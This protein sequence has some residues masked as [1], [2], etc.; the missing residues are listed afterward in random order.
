MKLTITHAVLLG[1]FIAAF[2]LLI[3]TRNTDGFKDLLA[4]PVEQTPVTDPPLTNPKRGKSD[5]PA[6]SD[7]SEIRDYI[8]NKPP[9]PGVD[10]TDGVIY[11]PVDLAADISKIKNQIR[12]IELNGR[13][14]VSEELYHQAVPIVG[15]I[16]RQAGFPLTDDNYGN[17]E[18][19]I[20]N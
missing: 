9:P 5:I 2:V 11:A 20:V 8:D 18:C 3:L 4:N 14:A 17:S 1:V 13:S 6:F 12:N 15:G 7:E 10:M 16:L 19:G